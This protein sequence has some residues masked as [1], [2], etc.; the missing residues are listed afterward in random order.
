MWVAVFSATLFIMAKK[1]KRKTL[2][3][4]IPEGETRD[5]HTYHYTFIKT[6]NLTIDNKK[7][8]LKKY[9]P[10]KRKHEW[11]IEAKLPPHSK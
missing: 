6:K 1:D 3:Y 8:K 7:L 9:N 5:H 4:L 10:V 2:L 11:F